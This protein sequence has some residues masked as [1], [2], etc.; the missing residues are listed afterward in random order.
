MHTITL[1][2][3]DDFEGWRAGAKAALLAGLGPEDVL[4][5]VEGQGGG[6]FAD[7]SPLPPPNPAVKPPTVPKDFI[8]LANLTVCHSDPERFALLYRLLHR[9]QGDRTLLK[10]RADADTHR[11]NILAKEVRRDLHK[12]KAFV[13][14]RK[15]G[16][17]AAPDGGVTEQF[18]SWFEPTHYTV[19]YGSGF[20]VRRFA[21]MHWSILTP[22]GCAHW[23]GENLTFS[24]AVP[25]S[26]APADDALE[27]YWKS[28]YAAIFNPARLK[29]QAMQSEMPKK[30]WHNLPEAALIPDLIEKARERENAMIEA[31]P[32]TPREGMMRHR[33]VVVEETFPDRDTIETLEDLR[34]SLKGC[35]ACPLWEPATQAVP[36]K[37]PAHAPIMFVGEQPGDKED[38]AGEPFIGPAGQVLRG[39]LSEIGHDPDNIYVTNAVKHFKFE[40]RGKRRLHKNPTVKEIDHC[41]WWLNREIELVQ[42]RVVVAL[43]GSAVRALT[44]KSGTI[45]ALRGGAHP[46]THLDRALSMVV[47]NHPSYILRIP[48]TDRAEQA[49]QGLMDDLRFA[50]SL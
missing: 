45:K 39:V 18:V 38:L 43:G 7:K 31:D 28:Y 19:R 17:V 36:G 22:K 37:G 42:P 15:T 40:P 41:K 6:L 3:P 11:I 14:F 13:R 9:L 4:F 49:R 24:E 29:T 48:E 46:L 8:P 44:G 50:L 34:A 16:E 20:F 47:T 12:M 21:S 10:Q 35:R 1:N 23:D 33:E 27:D 30:Y 26:E 2:A 5:A 25:K 32:T